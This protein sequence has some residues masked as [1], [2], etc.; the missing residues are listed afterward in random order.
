MI[1]IWPFNE[2]IFNEDHF[3]P[4]QVYHSNPVTNCNESTGGDELEIA[5]D[6]IATVDVQLGDVIARTPT[7]FSRDVES[8]L[9]SQHLASTVRDLD[10]PLLPKYRRPRN[11]K[12]FRES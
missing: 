9:L 5:G 11:Y 3:A 1:G 6:E 4:V 2:L 7:T 10:N 12:A 8:L